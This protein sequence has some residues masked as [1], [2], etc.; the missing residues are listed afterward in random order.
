MNGYERERTIELASENARWFRAQQLERLAGYYQTRK[1]S[2]SPGPLG[3]DLATEPLPLL[4]GFILRCCLEVTLQEARAQLGLES[5]RQD[6]DLAIARTTPRL[7]ARFS[8]L[9][10]AAHERYPEHRFNPHSATPTLATFAA[11]LATLRD[12]LWRSAGL[13]DRSSSAGE[14]INPSP[15][16]NAF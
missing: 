13:F 6:P 3:T 7:F 12:C 14:I 9:T 15:F 1:E 8:L 2:L 11:A 10:F 4:E 16:R 5:Q